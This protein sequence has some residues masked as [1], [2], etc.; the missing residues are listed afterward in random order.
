[1]KE[2]ERQKFFEFVTEALVLHMH[3]LETDMVY[4]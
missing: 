4:E 3:G 2:R 1:M